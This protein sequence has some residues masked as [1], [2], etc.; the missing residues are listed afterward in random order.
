MESDSTPLVIGQ[1]RCGIIIFNNPDKRC[2][3]CGRKIR[4]KPW[5]NSS[6][7]LIEELPSNKLRS[8][9]ESN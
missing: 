6:L 1:C 9:H 5:K 7:N 8:Y 3:K 4:V 2:P